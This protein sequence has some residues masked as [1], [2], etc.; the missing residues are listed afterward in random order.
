MIAGRA[1]VVAR[2]VA[3]PALI[4]WPAIRG[5]GKAAQRRLMNH[6]RVGKVPS[7]VI[8]SSGLSGK[9]LSHEA[10]YCMK[11]GLGSNSGKKLQMTTM[12]PSK[13]ASALW[14]GRMKE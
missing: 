2:H 12:L 11:R 1:P 13:K 5:F 8:Q 4:N 9:V 6:E 7:L 14:E 3:P 10:R